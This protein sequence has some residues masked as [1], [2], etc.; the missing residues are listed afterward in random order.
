[1][2]TELISHLFIHF[3]YFHI[4]VLYIYGVPTICQGLRYVLE[5]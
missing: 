3:S 5:V 4:E 1:M 2:N